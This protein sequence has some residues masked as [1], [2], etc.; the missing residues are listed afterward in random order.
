MKFEMFSR[1]ALKTDVPEHGLRRGDLATI[2][3]FHPGVP[4]QEPGY[5]LEV[6]NA[7]GDTVA[8]IALGESQIEILREDEILCARI[9]EA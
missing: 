3:D 6:F 1:V 7:V 2:V 8:V 9:L 5:S 4:G